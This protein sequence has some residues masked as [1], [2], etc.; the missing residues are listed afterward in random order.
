[1]YDQFYS[2]QQIESDL[3]F[4]KY[5]TGRNS[6]NL[7]P[8]TGL[9][10]LIDAC[11]NYL[12]LHEIKEY[13][14]KPITVLYTLVSSLKKLWLEN[15]DFSIQL[16]AMNTGEYEYGNPDPALN[17]FFK[18]FEFEIFSASQ[19]IK[20]GICVTLPQNTT[21]EDLQYATIDIQCK[22]PNTV[23]QIIK[24][25]EDFSS[26]L[27]KSKR[28]GV[29]GLAV[30]DCFNY[31]ERLIFEDQE[32]YE[33]HQR[34]KLSSS[35]EILSG[36]FTNN[37]AKAT[38]VLGV[39]TTSTYFYFIKG[40]GLRLARS[41]NSAF[42]FRPDRREIKDLTYKQAYKILT[43]FNPHPTWL[44]IENKILQT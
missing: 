11:D 5:L 17:H 1:M 13:E 9:Q 31:A 27:N 36:I 14:I 43:V 21:G 37:L 6:V 20:N 18:D 44:R 19:I 2:Q 38:R 34:Q 33:N 41:A 12:I 26:R 25:I 15:I 8:N 40:L 39:Y 23:N 22:H 29:F 3:A 10:K 42:A 30:E 16:K 35:D 32:D 7:R 4:L 24:N 28:Y